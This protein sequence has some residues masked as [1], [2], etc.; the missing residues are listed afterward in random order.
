LG[1]AIVAATTGQ[2][3][4][5]AM[6]E[7]LTNIVNGIGDKNAPQ[8]LEQS[9]GLRSGMTE[10]LAK[11]S[12]S[13]HL[14]LTQES[15]EKDTNAIPSAA[16]TASIPREAMREVLSDLAKE[17][18]NIQ[19]LKEA[20]GFYSQAALTLIG[21]E[22]RTDQSDIRVRSFARG[23]GEAFGVLDGAVSHDVL[24]NAV[25]GDAARIAADKRLER[26]IQAGVTVA[27]GG[28]AF[29][30]V[31]TGRSLLIS[32]AGTGINAG[33]GEFFQHRAPGS[34]GEAKEELHDTFTD[35]QIHVEQ[36]MRRW[37]TN[38]P[39]YQNSDLTNE[40]G[41]SYSNGMNSEVNLG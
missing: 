3:T 14:A 16:P 2:K 22:T 20:E 35:G 8:I 30:V 29:P 23:A 28:A 37:M 40:A 41:N 39:Q 31:S 5:P 19:A 32:M 12:E 33:V 17:P 10:A 38:N 25:K 13:L 34:V 21:G 26:W 11:N 6:A 9:A 36:M 1:D 18:S 27:A 15:G 24:E 4:S 7:A